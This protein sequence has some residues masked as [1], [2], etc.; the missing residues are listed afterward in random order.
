MGSLSDRA[1]PRAVVFDY[2]GTLTPSMAKIITS[3]ER[4]AMAAALG[5]DAGRLDVAWEQSFEDR[6]TGRTG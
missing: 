6:F 5:V 3:E 1:G 2:F 4:S